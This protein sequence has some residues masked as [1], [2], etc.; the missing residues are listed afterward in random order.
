MSPERRFM[1]LDGVILPGSKGLGRSLASLVENDLI[2]IVGNSLVFPVA[3]GLNLDPNFGLSDS[4]TDYYMVAASDPISISVPTKGVYAEAM[5]GH[6]NSCEEKDES[7]FWRWEESPI[8]DSPTEINPISTESRRAEPGNLQSL[9]LTNPM[10][11]IQ[12]APGAPDPTGLA[13]TLNLLGK[14]DTFR[15]ITGLS[16]NQRNALEA[17]KASYEATKTFGQ[18]AAKLEIQKMMN[19]RLD[20][21][22]KS[23]NNNPNLT[24]AQKGSLTEKAVNAYLGGGANTDSPTDDT[25][26]VKFQDNINKNL[27]RVNN[28][29]SGQVA[30]SKPDG[31]QINT[32]FDDGTLSSADIGTK[33]GKG[34]IVPMKQENENACWATVATMMMRWKDAVNYTI[35]QVLE[36][37]GQK[38]VDYFSENKGLPSVEKDNFINS[39]GMQG[40]PLGQYSAE[41]YHEWLVSYG[42]LWVTT[43]SDETK[44][45]SAHAR[46]ITGISDDLKSLELVDPA[47]GKSE[48]QSFEDFANVFREVITDSSLLPT[49]QVVHFTEQLTDTSEGKGKP[50]GGSATREQLAKKINTYNPTSSTTLVI[51]T[52]EFNT[53]ITGIKNYKDWKTDASVQHNNNE[54]GFRD[55]DRINHLV[56]HETAADTGTGFGRLKDNT[57]AHLGVQNDATIL[58]FNDLVE[59]EQHGSG[60]NSTSIGVEFVNKGW[61]SSN[62]PP[63]GEGIPA[64]ESSMTEDQKETYKEANGYLWTF[65]GYGFN[66]YKLPSSSVQLEKEVELVK[67][68]TSG[69]KTTLQSVTGMSLSN[70]FPSIDDTWLQLVSYDDVKSIWSFKSADIPPAA[71]QSMKNLFVF[72]SGHGLFLPDP[73]K[74]LKD[75]S[76]IISHNAFYEDHSDGS[77]LTLYT[78]LRVKK[79]KDASKAF[80]LAKKLMKDHSFDVSL[81]TNTGKKIRIINVKDTNLT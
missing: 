72:T 29:K 39:L 20:S 63:G 19:D 35:E 67:W 33:I 7:R 9:P 17:L 45:F 27:D 59:F 3:K 79:A 57:T 77:F 55:P 13:G 41:N 6:C 58:Q 60:I 5:M 23:I 68:L 70:A 4:L 54:N 61:L 14:A 76:G 2:G 16:E 34:G 18:E 40:E 56:L 51:N 62:P 66:I 49:T 21:A 47:S 48:I 73:E 74:K 80:E 31:T 71:E 36:M 1:L 53:G 10:I 52:V 38:Y 8:P 64:A 26:T 12:N 24:A 65:W 28:S 15:D 81:K 42:P 43:D 78:W 22:M 32:K 46:I 30:I 69:L 11:S 75:K 25:N 44:G 50:K 37:A